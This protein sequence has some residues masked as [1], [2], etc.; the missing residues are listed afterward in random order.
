MKKNYLLPFRV[1]LLC[2]MV[3]S[4]SFAFGQKISTKVSLQSLPIRSPL[5]TK[6]Y[7][8]SKEQRQKDIYNGNVKKDSVNAVNL[9][10]AAS[11]AQK[12]D[13]VATKVA[14]QE[15]VP[16]VFIEKPEVATFRKVTEVKGI[17][18]TEI[19]TI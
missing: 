14:G 16:P 19:P 18:I 2:C 3:F 10:V 15:N 7:S 5:P 4:S 1:C 9:K 12:I 11:G 17:S 8:A 6:D 13:E